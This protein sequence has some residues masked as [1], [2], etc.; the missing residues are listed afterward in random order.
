M[1]NENVH[2]ET[3][4]G[5]DTT[6]VQAEETDEGST[7]IRVTV[8]SANTGEQR[9]QTALAEITARIADIDKRISE[10]TESNRQ[11]QTTT[12]TSLQTEIAALKANLTQ[13]AEGLPEQVKKLREELTQLSHEMQASVSR[14]QS[15]EVTAVSVETIIPPEVP[16]QENAAGTQTDAPA[17]N[18]SPKEAAKPSQRRKYR[19]V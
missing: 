10:N 19:V 7:E 15:P 2:G 6:E 17:K 5:A 1:T 9:E 4:S 8:P 13:L 16:P 14:R 12:I 11:W 18:A 3:E